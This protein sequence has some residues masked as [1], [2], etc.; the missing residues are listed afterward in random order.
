LDQLEP[1]NA[2]YNLAGAIRIRGLLRADDLERA[3]NEIMRRHEVLRT[4]FESTNDGP[5][6]IAEKVLGI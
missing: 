2:A 6:G 1:G 3:L 5:V 4:T